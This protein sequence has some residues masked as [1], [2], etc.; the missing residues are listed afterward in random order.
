MCITKSN[1]IKHLER[2]P[3][4]EIVQSCKVLWS[5]YSVHAHFAMQANVKPLSELQHF[6][7]TRTQSVLNSRRSQAWSILGDRVTLILLF[8]TKSYHR[9]LLY[10]TSSVIKS[11]SQQSDEVCYF[12]EILPTAAQV[13]NFID[14]LIFTYILES[15]SSKCETF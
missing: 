8:S 2:L 4:L 7:A 9:V 5:V 15:L 11:N 6:L 13:N 10:N 14:K 3:S 1:K 12:A